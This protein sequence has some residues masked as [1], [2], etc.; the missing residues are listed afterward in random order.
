MRNNFRTADVKRKTPHE[1]NKGGGING[2]AE[3]PRQ[4]TVASI[5]RL[6]V[7]A[8]YEEGLRDTLEEGERRHE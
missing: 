1:E 8:L 4:L 2:R 3:R 7:R 6:L 5:T